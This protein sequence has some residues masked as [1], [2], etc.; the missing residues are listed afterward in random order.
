MKIHPLNLGGGVCET[1]P[2]GTGHCDRK[3]P[4]PIENFNLGWKL[5][6]SIDIFNLNRK[7]QSWCVSIYRALVAGVQR[8]VRSKI[9]IHDRALEIFDPKGRDRFFNPR[10]L[11]V[12]Q[13]WHCKP[14]FDESLGAG[15]RLTSARTSWRTSRG[16]SFGQALEIL[17][18]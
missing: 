8:R 3:N 7:V 5:S 6:I 17:K 2:E 12:L 18:K 1:P 15:Y 9:S 13:P 10:A 16:K 14:R 11:W 4:I